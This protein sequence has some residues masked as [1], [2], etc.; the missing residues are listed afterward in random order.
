MRAVVFC[1]FLVDR[2]NN[3]QLSELSQNNQQTKQRSLTKPKSHAKINPVVLDCRRLLPLQKPDFSQQL[4][5]VYS[6]KVSRNLCTSCCLDSEDA[7][8]TVEEH[9]SWNALK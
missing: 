3:L 4:T 6:L 9:S 1:F 5:N 2:G 8:S 7:K